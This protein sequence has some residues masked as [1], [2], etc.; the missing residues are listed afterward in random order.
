MTA[1]LSANAAAARARKLTGVSGT[2][3]ASVRSRPV[4]N[5]WEAACVMGRSSKSLAGASAGVRSRNEK[6][7]KRPWN[8]LRHQRFAQSECDQH[9][10]RAEIGASLSML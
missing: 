9:G 3:F 8:G 2:K 10:T 4:S 6:L 5:G 7:T 1:V